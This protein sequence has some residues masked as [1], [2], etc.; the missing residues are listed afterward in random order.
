M[1]KLRQW[2]GRRG[3][4]IKPGEVGIIKKQVA[5]GG[6]WR[7]PNNL[8]LINSGQSSALKTIEQLMFVYPTS[9]EIKCEQNIKA[10][11]RGRT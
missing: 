10:D 6:W 8:K 5:C 3:G 4:A 9:A 7:W 11:T 1:N 2:R